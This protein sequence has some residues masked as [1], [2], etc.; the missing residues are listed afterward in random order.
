MADE[1]VIRKVMEKPDFNP[2]ETIAGF[3]LL[4]IKHALGW[5]GILEDRDDVAHVSEALACPRSQAEGVLAALERRGLVTPT[6]VKNQW[7]TTQL[8]WQLAFRWKP[9]PRLTPAIALEDD[10]DSKAINEM[11]DDVPCSI[12]RASTDSDHAFEE[13]R[14]EV[15]VFVQYASPRVIEIS[16][17]IPDDYDNPA[18][19]S[20]VESSV[21]VGVEEA[22]RL[23]KALQAAIG[24][25]ESE[26]ARRAKLTP[27]ANVSSRDDAKMT[28]AQQAVPKGSVPKKS[29]TSSA[30][31]A[32]SASAIA[33]AAAKTDAAEQREKRMAE[34]A[35]EKKRKLE[36][37][38][39]EATLKELGS[40]NPPARS[41]KR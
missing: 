7:K 8:G 12:L 22:K 39:L 36:E 30:M 14:L 35:A 6:A 21:Y 3:P 41:E 9:P 5:V 13:A 4:R 10:D 1:R 18:S 33:R 29:N 38:A 28:K 40:G 32:M 37:R 24:R 17:S 11:L 31:S 16:V 15:G 19:S 27:R 20:V 23:A 34:R 26:L 2:S 25:A